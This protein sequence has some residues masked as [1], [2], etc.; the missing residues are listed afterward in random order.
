M[1]VGTRCA[2]YAIPFCPSNV[3]TNFP[4][5]W[6]IAWK[7]FLNISQCESVRSNQVLTDSLSVL[8]EVRLLLLLHAVYSGRCLWPGSLAGLTLKMDTVCSADAR[9]HIPEIRGLNIPCHKNPRSHI[10]VRVSCT[11]PSV[12]ADWMRH[13]IG[14]ANIIVANTCARWA[15]GSLQGGCQFCFIKCQAKDKRDIT[16]CPFCPWAYSKQSLLDKEELCVLL[17]AWSTVAHGHK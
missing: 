7:D 10:H 4:D 2:D 13:D 3:G 12:F 5:K 15:V 9:H 1:A 8:H 16:L 17:Y 14:T 6:L 11:E